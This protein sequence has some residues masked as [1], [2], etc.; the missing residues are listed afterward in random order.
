VIRL[1]HLVRTFRAGGMENGVANLV[2]HLDPQRFHSAIYVM[3][4]A[5]GFAERVCDP[6]QVVVLK[7][8]A[9]NDPRIA[10]RL[11]RRFRQAQPAILHTHGWGTLLEGLMA[12][13]LARVPIVVHGEHG[14]IE[15]RRRNIW[16]QRLAW[17]FADQLLSVSENHRRTLAAT[18]GVPPERI[19][20]IPNG[21]DLTRYRARSP[22]RILALRQRYH[23]PPDHL[24]LGS[25]GRLVEVKQYHHLLTAFAALQ[26]QDGVMPCRLVLIGDGPL[27]DKLTEL[28]QQLGMQDHV[29]FLGHQDHVHELLNLLDIFVLTSRSEGM[30][31]TI[32]E[33]MATGLP[34]VAT[35][36]GGTRELVV[37]GQ[38]G[39]L[40]P[41]Q[42]PDQLAQALAVLLANPARRGEMGRQARQRVEDVFALPIMVRAYETLYE[43]LVAARRV[44]LER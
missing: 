17:P 20:A 10:F 29:H 23:I 12:A 2:N 14:S 34:V 19:K 36:V 35:D 40:V 11:V 9:G 15:T 37:D 25:V 33:A 22:S 30:S 43:Q 24:V 41:P 8:R 7:Q 1:I 42:E 5:D 28:A 31:N 4:D 21:V 13:K 26:R 6:S 32:L 27:R 39:V 38:T 18:I 44:V 3:A 16:A